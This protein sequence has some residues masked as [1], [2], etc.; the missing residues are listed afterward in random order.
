[1]TQ[2]AISER[3]TTAGTAAAHADAPPLGE[4]AAL[5]FEA[6]YNAYRPLLRKIAMRNFGVS[7][8]DAESLV[9]DVFVSYLANLG[10]VRNS[11][12]YLIAG[13]CNASRK[14]TRRGMKER[15]LFC[16][17]PVC[18]ATPDNEVV[19]GVV[20]SLVIRAG[21][22]RLGPSCRDT[23]ERYCLNGET[24]AAIAQRRNTTTNYIWRLVTFCRSRL[25]TICAGKSRAA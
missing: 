14:H 12:A 22:A 6:I 4:D 18:A 8:D 21:L 1:M 19:E 24:A 15:A 3:L 23:I 25:R 20:R 5:R 10:N 2:V 9:Q 7:R 16:D 17:R 11:H 13:I